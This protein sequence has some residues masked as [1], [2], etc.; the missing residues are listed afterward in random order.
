[1]P[2]SASPASARV[3]WGDIHA[4]S[5]YSD[6]AQ[7]SATT[8]YTRARDVVRLDF[9]VLSD[10]DIFL[11]DTEWQD[12][13]RLAALFND[14]GRFVTFVAVEWSHNYH[15]NVYFRGDHAD[16]C[17]AAG[18][19]A[20]PNSAG[21]A[22]FYGPEVLAAMA[23]AHINHP[24][25]PIPWHEIDTDVTPNVEMFNNWWDRLW[26]PHDN[27]R[28]F[29]SL[30][31]AVQAGHRLGFVGASDYHGFSWNGPI[32]TGL[33]GCHVNALTRDD[34]L[35][36][37]RQRRC[38]ATD[39]DRIVLDLGVNGT[40]MGGETAAPIG[41]TVTATLFA[42]A[43]AVPKAIEIVRNGIVVATK[44][45]CTTPVCIFSAPVMIKDEY[46]FI[47]A[48][49]R[50]PS[51]RRAWATPVWVRGQCTTP[52]ACPT[53]RFVPAGTTWWT[54]C[55]YRW[56]VLNASEREDR[57]I[58]CTDGDPTCDSGSTPAEC[59]FDVGVCAGVTAGAPACRQLPVS[60]TRLVRPNALEA[61]A[62]AADSENRQTLMTA[63]HALGSTTPPGRCTPYVKVR[64][65]LLLRSD[66]TYG[67]G[68]RSFAGEGTDGSNTD[69]D[70]VRLR[71]LPPTQ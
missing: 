41:T 12:L 34:I 55:L 21:F 26:K 47:Y 11:T 40:P 7:G 24:A 23:G 32:G 29:G 49:V 61:A 58:D 52:A 10:H 60:T 28:G 20:C 51:G 56:R 16:I 37:L 2:W 45:D 17:G 6:D 30:L 64:V 50:Q 48:R 44:T 33:T 3:V 63:L 35:D 39:G 67:H 14:P 38:Y 53:E 65:P 4:H 66:G 15:M 69:R 36:A 27:E 54:E 57:V 46:T 18:M 70:F 62:S 13:K 1:M 42:S 8:F 31:W 68:Q 9:V 5:V 25:W 22:T 59:T 19:P 43:P 71:C